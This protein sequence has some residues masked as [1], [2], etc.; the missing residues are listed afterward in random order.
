MKKKTVKYEIDLSNPPYADKNCVCLMF[1]LRVRT[2][3]QPVFGDARQ[4][5]RL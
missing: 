3:S 4:I 5:N 1:W 2:S